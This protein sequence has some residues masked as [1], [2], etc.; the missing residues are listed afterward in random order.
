MINGLFSKGLLFAVCTAG[1]V[2]ACGSDSN[3]TKVDAPAVVVDAPKAI[4]AP[5]ALVGLGQKCN[6]QMP[7]TAPATCLSKQGDAF[8]FCSTEC[9][10]Q[11]GF[12]TDANKQIVATSVMITPAD[13]AKCTATYTGTVGTAA[14]FLPLNVTPAP[15]L[16]ANTAYKFDAYCQINCGAG[17]TCPT[18]LTCNSGICVP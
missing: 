16:A 17:N 2:A 6:A 12:M 7:C 11:S 4:D 15:P 8:G 5:A 1:L 14:C 3:T 10:H 9:H 13:D 18:G